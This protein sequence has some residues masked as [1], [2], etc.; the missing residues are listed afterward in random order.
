[1]VDEVRCGT[2]II[3]LSDRNTT[4]ELAAIPSLLLASAVHH[5]LVDEHLRTNAALIMESGTSA[6]SITSRCCWAS[7]LRG[8]PVPGL[9][10]NRRVD[11]SGRA[12][13]PELVRARYQYGKAL[14]KGVVK[15]MS[16]MGVS[17]VA[18]Y[19]GSQ[20]FEAVGISESVLSRYFPGF[21]SRLG[22]ITLEHIARS[23]LTLHAQ[24]TNRSPGSEWNYAT[25]ASTSGAVTGRSTC[26]IP[27]RTETPTRHARQAL[28]HL[29]GVHGSGGRS[30]QRTRD[31]T[32]TD[33]SG[34]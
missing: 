24:R 20:L 22:G 34:P 33:E 14:N 30:V 2:N 4:T 21:T 27:H 28:R 10:V 9:R 25:T 31:L 23:V 17:T 15:T 1:V 11:R 18:S 16:K 8:L 7:V 5:R 6:R 13:G 19:V 32:R 26:S 3:I 29:Q 12:D